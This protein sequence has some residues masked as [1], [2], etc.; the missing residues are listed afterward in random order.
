V[1]RD[2]VQAAMDRAEAPRRA[3]LAAV[4][5]YAATGHPP[6]ADVEALSAWDD[7]IS[8]AMQLPDGGSGQRPR[9]QPANLHNFLRARLCRAAGRSQ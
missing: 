3:W 2:P 4:Q 7:V 5:S 8:A 1:H 6:F 9:P